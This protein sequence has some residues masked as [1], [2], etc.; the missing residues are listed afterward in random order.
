MKNFKNIQEVSS[1]PENIQG[2]GDIFQE[3][4]T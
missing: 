2:Q 4:R 3:S 1:T